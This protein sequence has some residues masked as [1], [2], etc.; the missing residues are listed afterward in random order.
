MFR[1][2]I[3]PEARFSAAKQLPVIESFDCK[4]IYKE[5]DRSRDEGFPERKAWIAGMRV[6][7]KD[8]A[9]VS[10]FHRLA[11]TAQS[12]KEVRTELKNAGVVI[13]E[14]RT[15]RRSDN[16]DDLADMIHE[17]IA[18]YSQRGLTPKEAARMGRLGAIE[19]P[20]TKPKLGRMPLHDAILIWRDPQYTR[21]Q[22]L[23]LIN[24]D[25]R[26]PDKYNGTYAYRVLKRRG[27]PA[28]R[29]PTGSEPP[30]RGWV[31]FVQGEK[32]GPVKIGYS[33]KPAGRMSDLATSH[34]EKLNLLHIVRGTMET[35]RK[36]HARF[37]EYRKRGEWFHY[38][39]KLKTFI[40]EN[41]KHR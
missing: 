32:G 41:R 13:L 11:T 7:H 30:K 35:E 37:K 33:A 27:V 5:A 24:A 39:G 10:D 17:A 4:V 21:A 31:Y 3:R 40:L 16:A 34:H 28:G 22:A 1:A 29:R 19:S 14:G 38:T 12:L 9:L 18:F 26:Y 20:A 6:A 8:V 2:Y 25:K 23:A 36:F 15:K